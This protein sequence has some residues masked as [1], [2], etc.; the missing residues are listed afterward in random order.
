M[1]KENYLLVL[2]KN[3]CKKNQKFPEHFLLTAFATLKE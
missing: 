3:F 1:K 2:F